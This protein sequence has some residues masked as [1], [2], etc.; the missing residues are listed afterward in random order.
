MSNLTY[1]APPRADADES[2]YA[3]L[4]EALLRHRFATRE[5]LAY[6]GLKELGELVKIG[7]G[8]EVPSAGFDQPVGALCQ[9][10]FWSRAIREDELRAVLGDS[11]VSA[12]IDVGLVAPYAQAPGTLRALAALYPLPETAN[13]TGKDSV[14][15]W[16]A[17]DRLAGTEEERN[18]QPAD[19]VFCPLA[20]TG[21]TFLNL[22]PRT[23]CDRFLEVCA[24]CA[25]AALLARDFAS[26][27]VASDLAERSVAFAR[28]VA[29][30]NG[31]DAMQVLQGASYD[32]IEGRFDR[33]AAH[34]PYMPA[35]GETEI[36]YG[37]GST[38][39]DVTESLVRGL[40]ERLAPGGIFF[41]ATFLLEGPD[42]P[43]EQL[44]RGWLGEMAGS[45][46][47][48]I[49]PQY[50][51][52]VLEVAQRAAI[53]SKEGYPMV[54]RA[55]QF[56]AEKGF[57]VGIVGLLVIRRHAQPALPA[58][59][60]RRLGETLSWE[61][62]LWSLEAESLAAADL[63]G[64]KALEASY[65]VCDSVELLVTHRPSPEGFAAAGFKLKTAS[66]FAI[67]T[68]VDGWM[69]YLLA[70]ADGS[71]TGRQLMES[72]IADQMILPQTPPAEFARLLWTFV[73]GAALES[74]LCPL[75]APA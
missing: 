31:C 30:L 19:V 5:V 26:E 43:A 18:A 33:I 20:A 67:E 75:P 62:I 51:Q 12:A 41:S 28:F 16:A 27:I 59:A 54:E 49:Y 35:F 74:S 39:M 4:R 1:P 57:Q 21:A 25:P 13:S 38:G 63:D 69:S 24:G 32:G 9:L 44:V 64:S 14:V 17:S 45:F 15:L 40:P 6:T 50:F 71:M 52:S 73:G 8:G 56:L 68:Q 10:F 55:F 70:R 29:R 58:T 65:R 3:A 47:V 11:F 37:G 72:C 42:Q 36:Y 53:K 60:R 66:P 46:D 22:L 61:H 7:G 34:P 48:L 2:V 23:P